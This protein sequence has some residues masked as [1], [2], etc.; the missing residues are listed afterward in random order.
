VVSSAFV[1][2]LIVAAAGFSILAGCAIHPRYG[3]VGTGAF[4]KG[5]MKKQLVRGS[6]T[7]TYGFFIPTA[8]NPQSKCPVIIFLHGVGEG[9]SD[10]TSELRVG[11]APYI[12]DNFEFPFICIFPQSESGEWDENSEAAADVI[13]C[14]DDVSQSYS[15]DAE[16]VILTGYSTGGYGTYAIGA[17][18]K[19]RF[20]ALVPMASSDDAR[21]W[22][23][24]LVKMPIRAY[25]NQG[26][27]FATL[28]ANDRGMVEHIRS[29]GGKDQEFMETHDPGHNCW[30]GVYNSGELF[31]WML[32]QR[33]HGGA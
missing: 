24:Q 22:A 33:R 1:R 14:L 26:D 2:A 6:R 11:L 23:P 18:Y 3:W 12:A 16:R 13:T 29:L 30:D 9:G 7:R 15:V 8:Y 5:F 31:S 20:A 27:I 17:K 28:G 4:P 19:D 32:Q 25:C 10:G 21:R